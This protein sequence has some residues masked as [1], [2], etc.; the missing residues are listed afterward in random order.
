MTHVAP[1]A[2]DRSTHGCRDRV[3]SQSFAAQRFSQD[4][5]TSLDV[6]GASAPPRLFRP[7][8]NGTESWTIKIC[9]KLWVGTSHR[10]RPPREKPR[11][12]NGHQIWATGGPRCDQAAAGPT[13]L[14]TDLMAE[15]LRG[16]V[17]EA[18]K[19]SAGEK[20]SEEIH[21][22][23]RNRC[24]D[25]RVQTA[26]RTVQMNFNIHFVGYLLYGFVFHE[27]PRD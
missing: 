24:F 20:L 21:R 25:L 8:R 4:P 17:P 6:S 5:S 9:T 11:V 1:T 12:E 7:K 18:P 16:L 14:R 27:T 22:R 15:I 2:N 10:S 19:K 3:T 13:L 26:S 23:R